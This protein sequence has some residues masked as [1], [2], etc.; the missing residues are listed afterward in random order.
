MYSS[1]S[2][3]LS[4]TSMRIAQS[5]APLLMVKNM[6]SSQTGLSVPLTSLETCSWASSSSSS[7]S[8]PPVPPLFVVTSLTRQKGSQVPPQSMGGSPC[9]RP[10]SRMTT[11]GTSP[12]LWL[13]ASAAVGRWVATRRTAPDPRVMRHSR[14]CSMPHPSPSSG[15]RPSP[16]VTVKLLSGWVC[17]ADEEAPDC[18][19]PPRKKREMKPPTKPGEDEEDEEEGGSVVVV[20]VTVVV[21]SF[22]DSSR[23]FSSSSGCVTMRT[24]TSRWTP[25]RSRMTNARSEGFLLLLLLSS[26][27]FPLL[28]LTV[29]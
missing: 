10:S 26:L 11:P 5:L 1:R 24:V 23:S 12:G 18:L 22:F 14:R 29:S 4:K 21:V 7:S 6:V 27:P 15:T 28:Q 19:A 3:S 13:C 25:S 9:P 17:A 16:V 2:I 8:A 20:V